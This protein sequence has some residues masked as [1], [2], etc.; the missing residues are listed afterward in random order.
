MKLHL[1]GGQNYMEGWFNVDWTDRHRVDRKEN[2]LRPKFWDSLETDS[3]DQVKCEHFIEHIPHELRHTDKDG[4]IWFMEQL[5]RVCRDQ[6]T[7]EFAFP[8]H[9]GSWAYGDPTHCR[10]VQTMTLRYFDR[11]QAKHGPM[12]DYV[13]H[14]DFSVASATMRTVIKDGDTMTTEQLRE[15]IDREWNTVFEERVILLT[16]KPMREPL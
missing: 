14:A 11:V 9:Q 12:P 3:V 7:L 6:A 2:I 15:R 4:L 16:H 8:H 10:F 1:A 5:Y 13:I